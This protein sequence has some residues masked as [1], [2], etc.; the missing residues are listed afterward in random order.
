MDFL[1]GGAGDDV[2]QG[3]AARDR[4]IGGARDD[5]LDGAG[6][7]ILD[8]GPGVDTLIGG[9]SGDRFMFDLADSSTNYARVD[10]IVDF[11]RSEGDLI[12]LSRIDAIAAS[13]GDDAFAFIGSAAF[14][15]AGQLRYGQEG[16]NT[17]LQA[18]VDGDG[19]A[20]FVLRLDGLHTPV[21][22]DFV[23]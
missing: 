2:L 8:G 22:A 3:G 1:Y 7:D 20:D 6:S 23:L 4:L 14:S 21:E 11:D 19:T 16:G 12:D 5:T 10:R 9:A 13:G 15:A 17:Y 18:D